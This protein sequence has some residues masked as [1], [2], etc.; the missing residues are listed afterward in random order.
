M[1]INYNISNET[2]TAILNKLLMWLLGTTIFLIIIIIIDTIL[3]KIEIKKEQYKT[4]RDKLK[5][6]PNPNQ[7]DLHELTTFKKFKKESKS[8][9]QAVFVKIKTYNITPTVI[10][11]TMTP[12]Q[13]YKANNP[14]WTCNINVETIKWLYELE[15]KTNNDDYIAE[16][17]QDCKNGMEPYDAYYKQLPYFENL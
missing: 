4:L 3:S 7:N 1:F 11:K 16:Y 17:L 5:K 14:L 15:R 6:E 13:L 8:F 9:Q 12:M 10:E 2:Y